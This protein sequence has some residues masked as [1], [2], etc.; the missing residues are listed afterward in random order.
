M[1]RVELSLGAVE[2]LERLIFT[3]S[4]PSNT[5]SRLKKSLGVLEE[6]PRIGKQLSGRWEEMRFIL[7]PWRWLLIVYRYQ[8][9]EDL[10]LVLTIQDARSHL[11]ATS[12]SM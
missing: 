1:P 8:Q 12:G 4:L 7:G 6:F 3:H 2:D 5:R 10:V 11:S 9:A